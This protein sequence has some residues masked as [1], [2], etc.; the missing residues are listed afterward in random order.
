MA[1]MSLGQR[2][3]CIRENA[4]ATRN[5]LAQAL[6]VQ[7]STVS[8]YE[9]DSRMPDQ[10]T[11]EKI[12]YYFDVSLEE[13]VEGTELFIV[14]KRTNPA[15]LPYRYVDE[16]SPTNNLTNDEI[17]ALREYLQHYRSKKNLETQNKHS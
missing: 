11:L 17:H 9:N 8:N 10:T 12:A 14:F 16:I 1:T 15:T 5:Q 3:R 7:Y 13:L 4:G 6:G 2:L